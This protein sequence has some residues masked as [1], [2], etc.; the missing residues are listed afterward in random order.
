MARSGKLY[1]YTTKQG[2]VQN[3]KAFYAEQTPAFKNHNKVFLRLVN[4][5]F[6]DKLD[7]QDRKIIG[8]KHISEVTLIG[9]FD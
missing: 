8:V 3:A 6:S 4:E 5:D 1:Q 2:F 9:F 7:G